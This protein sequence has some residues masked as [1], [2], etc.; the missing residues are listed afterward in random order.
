VRLEVGVAGVGGQGALLAG[1]IIGLA[2]VLD[3]LHAAQTVS[4]GAE[5]RGSFSLS[6]VVISSEPIDYPFA[7]RLDAL[8]L[9]SSRALKAVRRLKPGGILLIDEGVELGSP[10]GVE[11]RVLKVPGFRR[12]EE[13]LGRAMLGNLVLVGALSKVLGLPS[14]R[15]LE[16]AV[17]EELPEVR[18]RVRGAAALKAV[19]LGYGLEVGMVEG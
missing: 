14:L 1:S 11:L 7:S 2:A 4:Y 17:L 5:V 3:G 15:S 13:E 6:E 8:L 10:P 16:R 19:Q 18:A 12:A 9:M